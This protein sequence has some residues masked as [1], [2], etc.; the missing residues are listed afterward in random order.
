ML[1]NITASK[2][3]YITDKIIDN[4]YRVEDAN[5]GRA[6]TMDI[7][8]LWQ[9]S[10][11]I[12]DGVRVTGSVEELSRGLI[13]F[14]FNRLHD[15]TASKLDLNHPS[16][17]CV[18]KMFD[19]V[20]GQGSPTNFNLVL[21][22]LSQSF[23][24]G[25]GRDVISFRDLDAANFITASY[26]GATANTW[27]LSGA[28]QQG[29]LKQQ[30]ID[31][32]ASG[33]LG[34]GDGVKNLTVSQNFVKGTE[35]LKMNI[36]TMVSATMA[37]LLPD[38]GFRLSFSG[39]EETDRKTRF[40]KRFATRHVTNLKLRPRIEVS[41]D[42]TILDNHTNF[43]FDL[44]G[45]LFLQNYHRGQG[46]PVLSGSSLTKLRGPDCMVLKLRTGS[47][48][49]SSF[50]SQ[51]TASTTGKGITG[52]YSSSFCIPFVSGGIVISGS[53]WSGETIANFASKT[54]SI[55]FDTYW[56][57]KDGTV[58]FHTGSLKI[59]RI[60]RFAFNMTQQDLQLIVTN[61]RSSYRKKELVNFRIFV[62]DLNAQLGKSKLPLQ[63][64]SIIL[65]EV[66]YRVRD[67][68]SGEVI[69]PF[70]RAGNGTRLSTDTQGLFF[71]MYMEDLNVGRSYTFD[72]LVID[73]GIE[74]V[75]PAR[76]VRFR[77]NQ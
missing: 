44:T 12:S 51:H 30:N 49:T 23:D 6:G 22:P 70:K 32:I 15:L 26:T 37:G 2:D 21:F 40:V 3:T 46:S 29:I 20:G 57:S 63:L 76:N 60:P 58:A 61:A 68:D 16:F 4:L 48:A 11:W 41:W 35:D 43:Y 14:D 8:R 25:K 77:V 75:E 53:G 54:G 45:S 69:L 17:N 18:L 59:N 28:N 50:V 24:E 10:T 39:S 74:S 55:I 31:V 9:E 65:D 5:V 19:V 52:L 42:D 1:L 66:Y 56:E 34:D 73:Q 38:Y 72:F 27:Y 62:Q 13:K 7:F 36:T 64:E 33:N 47:F 67:I 71:E